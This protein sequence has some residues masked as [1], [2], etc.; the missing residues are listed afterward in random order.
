MR[1]AIAVVRDIVLGERTLRRSVRARA[2]RSRVARS[3]GVAAAIALAALLA[4][5]W[6]D[7]PYLVPPTAAYAAVA[8]VCEWRRRPSRGER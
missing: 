8:V 4:R 1:A 7:P 2:H 3:L 6:L 5:G